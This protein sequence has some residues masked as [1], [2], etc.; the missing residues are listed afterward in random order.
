V[1]AE[2][3]GRLAVVAW[4]SPRDWTSHE[5]DGS[6]HCSGNGRLR[7]CE[8]GPDMLHIFGQPHST[9]NIGRAGIEQAGPTCQSRRVIGAAIWQP[10]VE[11]DGRLVA[12]VTD[13]VGSKRPCFVRHGQAAVVVDF[14][15][16][17]ETGVRT[18]AYPGYFIPVETE[19]RSVTGFSRPDGQSRSQT[20]APPCWQFVRIVKYPGYD[21]MSPGAK[22]DSL[23]RRPLGSRVYR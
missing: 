17:L 5:T 1:A 19:R 11:S 13:F 22:A 18:A 2:V 10:R 21:A 8:Q 16:H 7:V 12:V 3:D 14:V 23:L 9:T 6:A 20:G 15:F 4:S